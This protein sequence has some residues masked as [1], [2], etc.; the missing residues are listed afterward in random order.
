MITHDAPDMSK[1]A[2]GWSPTEAQ[3]CLILGNKR[4]PLTDNIY[5]GVYLSKWVLSEFACDSVNAMMEQAPNFAPVSV[6]GMQ[7]IKDQSDIG[8]FRATMWNPYLATQLERLFAWTDF[9]KWRN[10]EDTTPTDWWQ[11]GKHREWAYAGVSPM[12]RYMKYK[13]AGKHNC[14]YDAGFIYPDTNYRTL[15]SFV[16]YLSTNATGATRIIRDGQE[17]LPVW[18]R[19][20]DD[21]SRDVRPDEVLAESYPMKGS[22]LFFD[23]RIPHDVQKYDGAEGDR[24]IIRGDLIYHAV[25]N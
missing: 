7:D 1:V 8:S 22:V 13:T 23:H 18:E 9:P 10:C 24:I 14:H 4:I 16:L 17:A 20:H 19:N 2:G 21:W 11:H 12:L 25:E 3:S 15:M 5:K 6:Q